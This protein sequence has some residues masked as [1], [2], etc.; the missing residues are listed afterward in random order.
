MSRLKS[1][2]M[3]RLGIFV[4]FNRKGEAADY[5]KYL[6]ES[7]SPFLDEL[8]IVSNCNLSFSAIQLLDRF[9][10]NV[11]IRENSGLDAAAFKKALLY[12]CGIEELQQYDEVILFNDTFYGPFISFQEIFD[13]MDLREV[14]FWGIMAGYKSIDGLNCMPEGYIPDHIQSWFRAFRKTLICAREFEDYW[15]NYNECL[16]SFWDVVTNHEL[17]FTQYF[18]RLGYKWDIFCNSLPYKS[19]KLEKNYNFYSYSAELMLRK[20]NMPFLKRKP[21]S[22]DRKDILY[23]N[24][25]EDLKR[26]VSYLSDEY[27]YPLELIF[28]DLLSNY[29]VYD[30]YDSLH[31]NYILTRTNFNPELAYNEVGIFV[32]CL[33]LKNLNYFRP[34]IKSISTVYPVYICAP[35]ESCRNNPD[36]ESQVKA[37]GAV[38][39]PCH[40]EGIFTL[41]EIHVIRTYEYIIFIHDAK[42]WCEDKPET[43]HSSIL[44]NYCENMIH[45]S[46]FV[47]R[48][49]ELFKNEPCLGMLFTPTPLHH[50]FFHFYE[51]TWGNTYEK[52][53]ELA[54]AMRLKANIDIN[55][56]ILSGSGVFC[57]RRKAIDKL[58]AFPVQNSAYQSLG[59][60]PV[61]SRLLQ[62]LA[63]DAGFYSGIVMTQ[64]YASIEL[65]NQRYYL[66]GIMHLLS[67]HSDSSH[68]FFDSYL[69]N[70]SNLLSHSVNQTHAN[71][72]LL[73]SLYEKISERDKEIARLYPLTSLKVQLK[74][75][76][77][78]YLPAPIYKMAL[79]FKRLI[80]GPR[81]I[82]FDY[83]K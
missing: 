47:Y 77:K 58:L 11:F 65:M 81:Q 29:N 8:Y 23:M 25:G 44:F 14:D 12:Y 62:F 7:I 52:V 69:H 15:N 3:K 40:N 30:I 41:K 61:F 56:P 6:L 39:V 60:M 9:S 28:H 57:C 72:Q 34:Y 71:E 70:I 63:Q 53:V 21:F 17:I 66:S 43:I 55:K 5:V 35:A 46:D 64:E 19:E 68:L 83:A 22:M 76:I 78:K 37:M 26:A 50:S 24:G 49:V 74:L 32:N 67:E 59:G 82:A 80:W 31:L 54:K 4:F 10:K 73:C 2:H 13:T 16:T 36:W 48:M 18:E 45:S 1:Q 33:S 75:R 38:L 42:D 51:N 79:S 20:M 27:D